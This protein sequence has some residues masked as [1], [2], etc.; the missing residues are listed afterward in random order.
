MDS[1][2]FAKLVFY[3]RQ[4][5]MGGMRW[6]KSPLRIECSTARE[7][8]VVSNIYVE[9]KITWFFDASPANAKWYSDLRCDAFNSGRFTDSF[10]VYSVIPL[11]GNEAVSLSNYKN[12]LYER[13]RTRLCAVSV[14]RISRGDYLKAIERLREECAAS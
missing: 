9:V 1:Y 2:F 10:T 3:V 13:Y 12:D 5:C 7:S 14:V 8:A 4:F 11:L 6:K